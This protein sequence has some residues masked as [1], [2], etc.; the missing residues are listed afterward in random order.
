M[1]EDLSVFKEYGDPHRLF[2]QGM[3]SHG[4]VDNKEFVKLFNL[5]LQ[6]CKIEKP[7]DSKLLNLAKADFLKAI[8]VKLEDKCDL[9]I[10][11]S[12]DE[13]YSHGIPLLILINLKDRSA[14]SDKL[15]IKCMT[16][17]APHELDY[18][19]ILVEKIMDNP[20]K[21]LAQNTALNKC[22]EVASKKISISEAEAILSKLKRQKW[23]SEVD[24]AIRLSVRFIFE[25]EPYLREMFPDQVG[26]CSFCT[27]FV[28]R[29]IQCSR[30]D[31]LH[32]AYCVKKDQVD[33]KC[34]NKE[35]KAPLSMSAMPK[36]AQVVR[37]RTQQQSQ[38]P[39]KAAKRRNKFAN[40][41]SS[42]D[43]D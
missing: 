43:S 20:S 35:C 31:T 16:S 23:L 34:F 12:P 32:H 25:M 9:K 28:V 7:N 36:A 15:T 3:M 19:K 17:L 1:N 42:S 6:R 11:K 5:C 40:S 4:V 21:E 8:N 14:D 29:A 33:G 10:V 30:C 41:D 2:V 39:K 26:N 24:G 13:N 22:N 37:S 38:T 18:L 27:R